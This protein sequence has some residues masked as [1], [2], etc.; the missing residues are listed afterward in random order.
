VKVD[1]QAK[2][3]EHKSKQNP[4]D[5]NGDLHRRLAPRKRL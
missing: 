3:D 4:C 2:H 1:V 5:K